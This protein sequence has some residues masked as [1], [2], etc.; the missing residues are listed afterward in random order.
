MST[1]TVD[2]DV[3]ET[4]TVTLHPED[5][6]AAY[7]ATSEPYSTGLATYLTDSIDHPLDGGW[8]DQ[9]ANMLANEVTIPQYLLEQLRDH[10]RDYLRDWTERQTL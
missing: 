10:L 8:L 9:A 2:I 6:V 7:E 5:I 3:N 4:V 1:V